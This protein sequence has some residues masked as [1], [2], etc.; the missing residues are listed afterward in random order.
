[1]LAL[2]IDDSRAARSIISNILKEMGMS[3]LQAANGLEALEVLQ[4]SPAVELL[5]VDWNM[6]AMNGLEFIKAV[7]PTRPIA[8]CA[9]SWSP[10]KPRPPRLK[11]RWRPGPTNTS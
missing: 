8:V 10:R 3:V 5:L 11:W 1:M 2:V 7:V 9:S 6:P 4:R